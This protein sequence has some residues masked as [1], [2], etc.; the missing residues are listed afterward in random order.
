MIRENIKSEQG[1]EISCIHNIK[2]KD[3]D[4]VVISHGL[5]SSKESPTVLALI[6]RLEKEGLAYIAYD[7]PGHGD[8]PVEGDQFLVTNCVRDLAAVEAYGRKLSPQGRV[9]YFSSSFGAYINLL[10]LADLG[11]GLSADYGSDFEGQ[12]VSFL[13]AAA[14]NMPGIF[15]SRE[16]PELLGLL[17]KQGYFHLEEGYFRPLKITGE[18]CKELYANDVFK[19]YESIK[20]Q[21]VMIHGDE[22]ESAAYED[23]LA[24]AEKAQARLITVKGGKHRLMDG[25]QLDLVLDKAMEVFK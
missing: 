15:R 25:N 16:S 17:A 20:A 21:L 3:Q 13:R 9:M 6:E 11:Q 7:F 19:R 14:V 1:Y 4:F 5:G 10:Y 18:F 22:D 24:F 8:S 2:R 23:A 12:T